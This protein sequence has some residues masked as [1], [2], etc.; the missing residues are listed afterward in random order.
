M[1]DTA[2][3]QSSTA[4]M[5]GLFEGGENYSTLFEILVNF[6]DSKKEVKFFHFVHS[7]V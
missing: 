5:V 7:R 6:W 2:S 1:Y 4:V 3:E